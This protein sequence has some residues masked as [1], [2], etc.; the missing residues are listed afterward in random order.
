MHENLCLEL[1]RPMGHVMG[2]ERQSEPEDKLCGGASL[3]ISRDFWKVQRELGR[4]P[5]APFFHGLTLTTSGL[6]LD[7]EVVF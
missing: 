6:P 3:D 5:E 4:L 7:W 1:Q 2:L